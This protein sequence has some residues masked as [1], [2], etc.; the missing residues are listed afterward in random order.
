MTTGSVDH[1]LPQRRAVAPL[2]TRAPTVHQCE[3][4]A[5][6]QNE[7]GTTDGIGQVGRSD[8]R[9]PDKPWDTR[10]SQLQENRFPSSMCFDR[11]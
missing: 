5:S 9:Q 3:E 8:R 6:G 10:L 1:V 7:E 4:C 2:K 11:E